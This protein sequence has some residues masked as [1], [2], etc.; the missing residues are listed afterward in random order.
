MEVSAQALSIIDKVTKLQVDVRINSQQCKRL[1]DRFEYIGQLITKWDSIHSAGGDE[2]PLWAWDGGEVQ[3]SRNFDQLLVVLKK[4]EALVMECSGQDLRTKVFLN[5][6]NRHAFEEIHRDI[7]TCT[8]FII[9]IDDLSI[10][11]KGSGFSTMTEEERANCLTTDAG[12]DLG[13]IL[14]L[15]SETMTGSWEGPHEGAEK[16]MNA[17]KHKIKR[18]R[19]DQESNDLPDG[20]FMDASDMKITRALGK[21]AHN[22]IFEVDWLGCKLA[23]KYYLFV[24]HEVK[25][26]SKLRH[27]HVVQIV[28]YSKIEDLDVMIMEL[29]DGNLEDLI[30]DCMQK[31]GSSNSGPFSQEVTLDILYQIARGMQYLHDQGLGHGQLKCSNV[32]VRTHN[33]DSIEV[34]VADFGY[35][36][37]V[38]KKAM[39]R[40]G[41]GV[42]TIGQMDVLDFAQIW[43]AISSGILPADDNHDW[44]NRISFGEHGRQFAIPS[45]RLSP[46][47]E[48]LVKACLNSVARERPTFEEICHLLDH[49][50]APKPTY[51]EPQKSPASSLKGMFENVLNKVTKFCKCNL[52]EEAQQVCMDLPSYLRIRQ[53][54][55]ILLGEIGQGSSATV[56]EAEWMGVKFAV[57]SICAEMHSIQLQREVGVWIKLRHPRIVQ[58]MGFSVAKNSSLIVMELLG[59][60]LRKLIDTRMA[61]M[62]EGGP[63]MRREAL[64]VMVQIAEG[65]AYLHKQGI[66]HRDLKSL[67]VLVVAQSRPIQ[68]KIA[69]FGI[70]KYI[71]TPSE[72][73]AVGTGFWRAPEVLSSLRDGI[74]QPTYTSK[75]DVYSYGMTCYEVLTGLIPFDEHPRSDYSFVLSGNRPQLP[76]YVGDD[77]ADLIRRCWHQQPEQRPEFLDICHKLRSLMKAT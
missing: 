65:M 26:L 71:N 68:V 60:D 69:D 22:L 73:G 43:C 74:T 53:S 56:Y 18:G 49:I 15:G 54:C 25:Q 72:R 66:M 46:E 36:N 47:V 41:S 23:A 31:N 32:L 13:K 6:D 57:K 27:P 40:T 21:G 39:Y 38:S 63:F 51:L 29:M 67:N 33:S 7:D 16:L 12:Q 30:K 35:A 58:L 77:V 59:G 9:H 44:R 61:S 48:G 45:E 24:L 62:K 64:D 5:T 50:R 42:E 19:Y 34:K 11:G 75:A 8:S 17:V 20:I 2:Q 70:S 55:I 14:Q 52:A 1:V 37:K 3:V 4:G 28:G 10:L 76:K